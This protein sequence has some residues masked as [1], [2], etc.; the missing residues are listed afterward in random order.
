[1]A[2]QAK[3]IEVDFCILGGGPGGI[4][5]A[6]TAVAFGQRVVLIE[7][8]KIGGE[9][10]HYATLPAAALR[11]VASR[12]HA[13]RTASQ[14]GLDVK[15]GDT[16]WRRLR[17]HVQGMVAHGEANHSVARLTGMGIQVVL[18]AA[19]FVD[20][21]TVV[22]GEVRISAR[23][24]IIAT[25]SS[26]DI[27][28]IPGLLDVPFLTA[29]TLFSSAQS[30]TH[31]II[32]G[33]GGT[34]LDVAQSYRRLGARVTVIDAGRALVGDDEELA[35][36][37]VSGLRA[38]GVDILEGTTVTSI[39][40]AAVG[41]SV[42]TTTNGER[43]S[44]EGSHLFVNVGRR[45]NF[46]AL[47]LDA[48]GI[49]T[50]KGRIKTNAALQTSNARIYAI[51]DV[52]GEPYSSHGAV[53]DAGLAV[54]RALFRTSPKSTTRAVHRVTYTTPG[55]ASVGLSEDDAR[56]RH[57]T[58]AVQRWGFC[59]ND[60]A[61]VEGCTAGHVKV[62][63]DGKGR[64]V[65]V[66]IAGPE[67]GE[68]IEVWGLA[69]SQGLNIKAMTDIVAA[70]PSYGDVNKKAALRYFT[71]VPAKPLVRKTIAYMRKLG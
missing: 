59:D 46:A 10:A 40:T 19:R 45:G 15:A 64:I 42:A 66:S 43:S 41:V 53:D 58:I 61:R 39:A 60:R 4:A 13:A 52:R 50:E 62:V 8:H 31:L 29:Q 32:L 55:L 35:S 12:A 28:Q 54:R 70:A 56:Q 6:Q 7:T 3:S 49:A 22:A 5:A 67:A 38:E 51:G 48:A 27:P 37:V 16:D 26:P 25:G 44:I 17:D 2:S 18:A 11:A 1:M 68:L 24:F 47:G 21:Q 71:G 23:T 36:V 63:T 65:G 20:K 9:C 57:G 33:G 69:L 34:S 14:F 30:I